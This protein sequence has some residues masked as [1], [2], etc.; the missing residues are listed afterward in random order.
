MSPECAEEA[1]PASVT[2]KFNTAETLVEQAA[3]TP[4][5]QARKALNRAKVVLRQAQV[6]AAHAAKGRKATISSACAAVLQQA[7]NAVRS[8]LAS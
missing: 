4:G 5:K 2:G 6:K 7:V 8:G 3:T 1:V